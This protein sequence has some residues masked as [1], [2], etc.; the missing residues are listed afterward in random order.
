MISPAWNCRS[1]TVKKI[2]QRP[3]SHLSF[4]EKLERFSIPLREHIIYRALMRIPS[5]L[6]SELAMVITGSPLHLRYKT[7]NPRWDL[8]DQYGHVSDDDAVADIDSHAGIVFF[9]SRGYRILSHPTLLARIMARH[10]AVIVQKSSSDGR[11][12]L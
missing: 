7:L 8:I 12:V 10:E 3:W 9:K 1:W 5:R 2:E 4:L 6:Y 11:G